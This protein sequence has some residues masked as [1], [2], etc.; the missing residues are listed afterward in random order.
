MKY[1]LKVLLNLQVS[2]VEAVVP[3]YED[4]TPRDE[5]KEVLAREAWYEL[6]FVRDETKLK[7]WRRALN[8]GLPL[9]AGGF[10]AVYWVFGMMQ[11]YK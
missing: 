8:W 1:G 11:Y 7:F 5:H 10:V 2:P 6:S 9:F 3:T 4:L